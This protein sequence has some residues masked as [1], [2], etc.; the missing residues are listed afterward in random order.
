[1]NSWIE[2]RNNLSFK[3]LSYM[4]KVNS[5]FI[6]DRYNLSAL[7]ELWDI[8]RVLLWQHTKKNLSDR[9]NA[10][11]KSSLLCNLSR[12][13]Y[14]YFWKTNIFC[15]KATIHNSSQANAQ[16]HVRLFDKRGSLPINNICSNEN[17]HLTWPSL[18][19][20]RGQRAGDG[21]RYSA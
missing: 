9:Q 20:N 11:S 5:S 13:D 3:T 10:S 19:N 6:I 17:K 18:P 1:M 21:K 8:S 14:V 4:S 7:T 2:F 15:I 16:K 12:L